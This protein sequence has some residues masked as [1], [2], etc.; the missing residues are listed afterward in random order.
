MTCSPGATF[1]E[2][3]APENCTL[4]PSMNTRKNVSGRLDLDCCH[5]NLPEP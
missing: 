5:L 2:A 4:T 3:F 1:F